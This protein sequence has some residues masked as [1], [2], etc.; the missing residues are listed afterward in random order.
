VTAG[1]LYG[2]ALLEDDD[3]CAS[4]ADVQRTGDGLGGG[5][6]LRGLGAGAG[7]SSS[8]ETIWKKMSPARRRTP[9]RIQSRRLK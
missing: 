8:P 5:R 9:S 7:V 2:K 4:T 6:G 3:V 1:L